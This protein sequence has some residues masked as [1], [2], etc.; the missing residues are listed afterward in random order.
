MDG[1]AVPRL[2]E[3]AHGKHKGDN[4]LTNAAPRSVLAVVVEFQAQRG[5]PRPPASCPMDQRIAVASVGA[6][7]CLAHFWLLPMSTRLS[8]T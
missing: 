4:G 1:E 8:K 6:S 5:G 7:S 3:T 2:R